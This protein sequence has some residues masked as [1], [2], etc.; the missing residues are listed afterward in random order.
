[1]ARLTI[2][3]LD[4]WS[5]RI[6]RMA[7]RGEEV[8]KAAVYAGAGV[9][10]DAVAAEINALPE[11][12]GYMQPGDLR[13]VVTR[14]EKAALLSHM[15]IAHMDTTGGSVTTVIGF[16]GYSD[17]AT[18]KYPNGVPIPLIAR[19]IESGSSVRR[20]IPFMRNAANKAKERVM[21]AM[22]EAAEKKFEELG[23]K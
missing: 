12:Q 17:H 20:K 22:R 3:G 19:S 18:K 11:Q 15:G 16:N 23:G 1:M 10:A 21:N 6:Q 13:N 5:T 8:A 2:Q 9:L 14:D 4:D 7:E